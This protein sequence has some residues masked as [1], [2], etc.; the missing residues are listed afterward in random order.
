MIFGA[1]SSHFELPESTGCV[2]VGSGVRCGSSMVMSEQP[3]LI[4]PHCQANRQLGIYR[5]QQS[6]L[7]EAIVVHHRRDVPGGVQNCVDLFAQRPVVA[8][9]EGPRNGQVAFQTVE[10][11]LDQ[12]LVVAG[13]FRRRCGGRFLWL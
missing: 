1:S 10:K 5:R 12:F 13:G 2:G 11:V 3:K 6:L 9:D 4:A 7:E 8:G